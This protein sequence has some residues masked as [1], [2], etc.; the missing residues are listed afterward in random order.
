M[1]IKGEISKKSRP[2]Y[3]LGLALLVLAI[4]TTLMSIIKSTRSTTN[5]TTD[6]TSI[7]FCGA[8]NISQPDSFIQG[9]HEF[10]N[11]KTQ[12]NKFAYE[13]QYSSEINAKNQY[14]ISYVYENYNEGDEVEISAWIKT[15]TQKSVYLV[16]MSPADKSYYHQT[17]IEYIKERGWAQRRLNLTLPTNKKGPIKIFVYTTNKTEEAY[18]DNFKIVNNSQAIR[19]GEVPHVDSEV[20]KLNFTVKGIDKLSK[21]RDKALAL[22]L[23]IKGEDDWVK[24]KFKTNNLVETDV[25]V[26]LKGDWTDHLTG[27]FWSYR[28]KMPSG[29][30]WNRVTTF[31]LQNPQTRSNLMEWVFHKMLERED[32][33]T[34][35]YDFI[36]LDV[37]NQTQ[38]TY[39][40]EE[41]FEK[42]IVEYKNR[43]EGVVIRYDE[44]EIWDARKRD[45]ENGSNYFSKLPNR[46][47]Q[48]IISPFAEK[49]V[50]QNEKLLEQFN[51]ASSLLRG[52]QHY[53]LKAAE[54]FDVNLLAK[55]YAISEIMKAY[56][57]TIWH[58]TRFY[59][60]PI[61]KK[62]EPIGFDGFTPDGAFDFHKNAFYGAYRSSSLASYQK[63]ASLHLFR[64]PDF[65]AAYTKY[66]HK[67]SRTEYIKEFF[68][69]ISAELA[70]KEK[71][72]QLNK[73]NYTYN[74][75]E[76][77]DQASTI[78]SAIQITNE[79]TM[80]AFRNNC[81]G[82]NCEIT[83]TNNHTLPLVC[84]GSSESK[85][86]LPKNTTPIVIYANRRYN[87]KEYKNIILP[88]NHKYIFYKLAG[89]DGTYHSTIKPWSTPQAKTD[90]ATLSQLSI[91]EGI[92][93]ISDKNITFPAG[94]YTITEPI[95]IPK[96]HT[97]IIESGA[98]LNFT[99]K[100]YFLCYSPITMHGTEDYPITITS[101]DKSAQGFHILQA[102]QE[103]SLRHCRFTKLNTLTEGSWQMTGAVTFYES[104]VSLESVTISHN[105][106]E[107]ALNIIRTNFNA[108]ALH[109]NNT[110]ADGFDSDFC[111]GKLT[112]AMFVDTG[113]DGI[114]FSGSQVTIQD[115]VLRKIGDKGISAGEQATLDVK[116]AT[117]DQAVIGVASKDLST[118]TIENVSMIACNKGFAAYQKKPEFGPGNI[119]VIS[120][121]AEQVKFL[122]IAE[123][124]S[125]IKLP[126]EN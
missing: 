56:H 39:A 2:F 58:N 72:I 118:V 48:A 78:K 16:A 121:E 67:F 35:R 74:E 70:A 76:V 83:L 77:F 71:L 19:L 86:I 22:G 55:Y 120:Y 62:L 46:S 51:E 50:Y 4:I 82:N 32:V 112:N 20:G 108:N 84:I 114:D 8:E 13:G 110:F 90:M 24:A 27:D 21:K 12:S 14:S 65:N 61:I 30:S 49:K 43:R 99:N 122:Q 85:K 100:A 29:T 106:C 81:K 68:D 109:I 97:V 125:I 23:L 64:D 111:S 1:I 40:F 93:Q 119:K 47:N 44:T 116:N 102:G 96:S 28:I 3:K 126:S 59:Y 33:L 123:N 75:K 105:S 38:K 94:S 26:R 53:E 34:P 37:N 73:P 107:D 91:P 92:A 88:K 79:V 57:S 31:S 98:E 60:N 104:P 115:I 63:D 69:E 42:Q 25:K 7:I 52:F 54:V 95:K 66:L 87:T 17:N 15:N 5:K 117:I 113:N 18:V 124:N 89:V 80:N 9:N 41:H 103:S 45:L 101:S 36:K 6:S 11:G 10:E